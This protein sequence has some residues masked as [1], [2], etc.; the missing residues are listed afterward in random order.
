MSYL[1]TQLQFQWTAEDYSDYRTFQNASYVIGMCTRLV[2]AHMVRGM[3][4]T[5]NKLSRDSSFF[6]ILLLVL[7]P[8]SVLAQIHYAPS[9][10]HIYYFLGK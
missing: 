7:Q 5:A 4:N 8:I 6:L 10:V 2:S 9:S 1:Y 3:N